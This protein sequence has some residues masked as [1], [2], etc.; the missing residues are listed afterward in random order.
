MK[1]NFRC[2]L[3]PVLCLYACTNNHSH[4]AVQV[5]E[6][7]A[8]AYELQQL[9]YCIS[10]YGEMIAEQYDGNAIEKED[11][12][13]AATAQRFTG[14]IALYELIRSRAVRGDS[15]LEK[16]LR[17]KDLVFTPANLKI[18]ASAIPQM[19][20]KL[21]AK[22]R[23]MDGKSPGHDTRSLFRYLHSL[24]TFFDQKN[25]EF[26]PITD[27]LIES[28]HPTW[29]TRNLSGFFGWS[30]FKWQHQTILWHCIM[31]GDNTVLLMKW[32]NKKL[33]AAVSYC[34]SKMPHPL[35]YNHQ[36]PLQS[37]IILELIRSLYKNNSELDTKMLIAEARFLDSKGEHQH[38]EA[39]YKKILLQTGDS[40]LMYYLNEPVIVETGSVSDN[41]NA[42]IPFHLDSTMDIQIFAGGQQMHV[43]DHNY[44][45]YQYDNVQVFFGQNTTSAKRLQVFEFNYR[46]NR[47]AGPRDERLPDSWLKKTNVKYVFSDPS[48]TTYTLEVAIPWSEI[49]G[50]K[51]QSG[52]CVRSNIF[53]GDSDWEE[54]RRT[55]VLSWMVKRGQAWNDIDAFGRLCMDGGTT[56]APQIDGMEDEVWNTALRQPVAE[57]FDGNP[58]PKGS[59]GWFKTLYDDWNMYFLFNVA[60]KC[61][62]L[63]GIV[64]KDKCCIVNAIT[65][66]I[67][68]KLS[69]TNNPSIIVSEVKQVHLPAGDYILQYQSDKGNSPEGWYTTPPRNG[70]YGAV[71][72]RKIR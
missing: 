60:D 20:S 9:S 50:G 39:L 26:A 24:N 8:K 31:N 15:A 59:A 42:Q 28:I 64:L 40:L 57:Q 62:N 41:M 4:P 69:A 7:V 29:Y 71:I 45:P 11:G 5:V 68:W 70:I 13:F 1:F 56:Q 17:I 3:L 67:V 27:T 61:K 37:P 49:P 63:T 53:I 52:R 36:D 19:I 66:E 2:V 16:D 34:S 30:V 43:N 72:Y 6:Q 14:P 22:E 23:I 48:D 32:M 44:A 54:N 65:G 25:I 21:T 51:P 35:N 10:Q 46:Y 38:A 58:T 18:T 12:L 33:F 55:S 47:I